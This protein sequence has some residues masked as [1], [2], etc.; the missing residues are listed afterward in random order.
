MAR[1]KK[2]KNSN[3]PGLKPPN[4]WARHGVIAY[5]T[6]LPS[7]ALAAGGVLDLGRSVRDY[8]QVVHTMPCQDHGEPV[9]E[10]AWCH[11]CTCNALFCSCKPGMH[12]P[13]CMVHALCNDGFGC[14][15]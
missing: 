12:L 14:L 4:A 13:Q 9:N 6:W 2:C 5:K 1:S 7:G 15:L 10:I 8:A 3:Q 11:T